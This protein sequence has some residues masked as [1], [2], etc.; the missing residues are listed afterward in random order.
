[1]GLAYCP[2]AHSWCFGGSFRLRRA[3]YLAQWLARISLRRIVCGG[4]VG[5][6]DGSLV[7]L[8]G[9]RFGSR[10]AWRITQWLVR[11]A[12]ADRSDLDK[13][14]ILLDGSVVYLFG[15]WFEADGSTHSVT[16]KWLTYQ[17]PHG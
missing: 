10:R 7:Y 6:S 1:M 14:G 5:F 17:L 15:G 12:S 11:G 13:P 4:P 9:G 2:T 3:Q 8:F 16:A